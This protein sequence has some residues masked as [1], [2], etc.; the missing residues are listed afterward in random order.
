[1]IGFFG[2][3]WAADKHQAAWTISLAKKLQ[4][5]CE[6]HA[7]RGSSI[8]HTHNRLIMNSNRIIDQKFKFLF[9]TLT[10]SIRIPFTSDPH[11]SWITGIDKLPKH[12]PGID[13][14]VGLK[15]KIY[16]EDFF[17]EKL[18]S[19]IAENVINNII[20]SYAESTNLILMSVFDEYINLIESKYL[21]KQN[22]SYTKFP[23]MSLCSEKQSTSD[24]SI[25]NHMS[26]EDN[27]M[28]ANKFYDMITSNQLY[29]PI[30]L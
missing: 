14:T 18:H 27:Q 11:N 13:P 3:S 5:K 17:D 26:R 6:I 15:H 16:Y 10:S 20:D 2:D 28:V 30:V 21:S 7:L 23:L 19:F 29:K 9:V 1:M 4:M 8:W 22:F 12:V 25:I 24:S